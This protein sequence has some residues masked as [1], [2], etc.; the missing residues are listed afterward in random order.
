MAHTAL[1]KKKLMD[2]VKRLQGQ[3]NGIAQ[4]LEAGDDC[5]EVLQTLSSARGALNGLMGEIIEGHIREH[6][7]HAKNNKE[8]ENAAE[9]TIEILKSYWK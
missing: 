1:N 6:V 8:S 4:A 3:L 5:Y 9:E 7:I 2:R